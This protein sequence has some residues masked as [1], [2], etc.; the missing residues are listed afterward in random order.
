MVLQRLYLIRFTNSA[1]NYIKGL[2]KAS[3]TNAKFLHNVFSFVVK[4]VFNCVF[5]GNEVVNTTAKEDSSKTNIEDLE[6]SLVYI[7][8]QQFL[9]LSWQVADG[10]CG[11][12]DGFQI[13]SY[14]F[15]GVNDEVVLD[16]V[17]CSQR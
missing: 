9:Q 14:L 10:S 3:I 7:S 17:P 16:N 15:N 13:R 5:I 8:K 6:A 1:L 2:A 4:V 12:V 11:E